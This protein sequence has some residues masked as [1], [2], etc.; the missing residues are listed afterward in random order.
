MKKRFTDCDKWDDPWYRELKP[1]HKLLWNY[2]CDKCDNSGV[3]KVDIKAASFMIGKPLNHIEVEKIFNGR[4]QILSPEKWFIVK[5]LAFQYGDIL[6]P[7]CNPHKTVIKMLHEH[8]LYDIFP[9]DNNNNILLTLTE[10]SNYPTLVGY[11]EKD[12]DQD[13]DTD[14]DQ[15]QETDQE[16][17][18]DKDA[19]RVIDHLNRTVGSNY[20]TL[21]KV[22]A[23]LN[24]KDT[25]ATMEECIAVIDYQWKRAFMREKPEYMNPDTLFGPDNFEKYRGMLTVKKPTPSKF[26]PEGQATYEA[27]LRW[28]A[29]EEAKDAGR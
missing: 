12:Q 2:M 6:K 29:S 17:E 19:Q 4:V 7:T 16:Q 9:K 8:H 3:W 23:C 26:S 27:G 13:Q 18:T 15:D 21:K 24:K 25:P 28:I 5:F 11:Q 22:K 20:R 1:E 10:F 14:Q